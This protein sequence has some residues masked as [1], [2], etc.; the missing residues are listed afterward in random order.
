MSYFW[1]Q[2]INY[3]LGNKKNK[4]FS[5]IELLVVV[6]ILGILSAVALP[7]LFGQVE[8]ARTAEARRFLGVLN[9]AQQAFFF[10]RST[11]ATTFSQLGTDIS[12]SS[13]I[14]DY[15]ILPPNSANEIRHEATPKALYA[16]D[17]KS[18]ESAIFRI[19]NILDTS[20][21][22]GNTIAD[23]PEIIATNSCNNGKFIN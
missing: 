17:L 13:Q 10:E 7:N 14:Y 9:R 3:L 20:V 15:V 2:R 22:I 4:G 6:I 23:N 12:S 5:L 19:G 18:L 16:N 8:K 21:C 1:I 11:F